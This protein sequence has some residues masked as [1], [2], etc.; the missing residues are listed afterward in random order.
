MMPMGC[1]A[2]LGAAPGSAISGNL[3]GCSLDS[4]RAIDVETGHNHYCQT[5]FPEIISQCHCASELSVCYPT[6]EIAFPNLMHITHLHLVDAHRKFCLFP[7]VVWTM[8][9][10]MKP[11]LDLAADQ[12]FQAAF[13]CSPSLILVFDFFIAVTQFLILVHCWHLRHLA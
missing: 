4:D 6:F 11:M 12:F 7:A 5:L 13:F 1:F 3:V 9:S 8:L 10:S 2:N